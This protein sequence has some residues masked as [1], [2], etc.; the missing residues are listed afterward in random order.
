M[1]LC[2]GIVE[3]N[4]AIGVKIAEA[5]LK[6]GNLYEVGGAV[7]D[8][9]LG[10]PRA[11]KDTDYLVTGIPL[12]ELVALLKKFGYVDLVG[13]FFGVIKFTDKETGITFDISLPRKE[14]STGVGH[15][16]FEVDFDPSLPVETDLGRRDFT[17]NA[18]AF[19]VA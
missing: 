19:D 12:T 15:K 5:V 10:I 14:K 7:R 11:Q 1:V 8:R 18:M 13:R 3:L 16:D 2:E 4:T 6:K 17:I 9:L